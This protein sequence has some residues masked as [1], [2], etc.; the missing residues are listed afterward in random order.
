MVGSKNS[1]FCNV[2]ATVTFSAKKE[3]GTIAPVIVNF[4][5]QFV[6]SDTLLDTIIASALLRTTFEPVSVPYIIA[7]AIF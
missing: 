1:N 7:I 4:Q 3:D 5:E 6:K 2:I